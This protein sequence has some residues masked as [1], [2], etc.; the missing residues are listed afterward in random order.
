MRDRTYVIQAGRGAG[1]TYNMMT[2]IR[3]YMTE[4]SLPRVL[5]VLPS[6]SHI[7]WWTRSWQERFPFL[8]I[9]RIV[10]V[11]DIYRA[12]GYRVDRIYIDNIDLIEDGWW[13]NEL[14]DLWYC[15]TGDDPE[16]YITSSLDSLNQ[17][18][19]TP[20]EVVEARRQAE[21]RE[22]EQVAAAAARV[23]EESQKALMIAH[24]KA[25]ILR[26]YD[27]DNDTTNSDARSAALPSLKA[28]GWPD[29][30]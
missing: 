9:P 5:V 24:M 14:N 6:A 29:G 19:H 20:Y 18:A 2:E 7:H 26:V 1:K 16:V 25:Y 17:E 11:R 30:S 28:Y 4:H 8:T 12:S 10:S 15:L 13:N 3:R 27:Q 23:E 21:E 22:Q